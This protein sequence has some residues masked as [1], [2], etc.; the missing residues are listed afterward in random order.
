M[1][2]HVTGIDPDDAAK[3]QN[4]VSELLRYREVKRDMLYRK[5]LEIEEY[6]AGIPD[7]VTRTIFRRHYI[8]GDSQIRIGIDL[9]YD[10]S[11]IS[12][13]IRGYIKLHKKHN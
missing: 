13:K 9:G 3:R 1:T 8:D 11:V 6:I 5:Q 7:S 4:S 10:Q 12:R 2:F